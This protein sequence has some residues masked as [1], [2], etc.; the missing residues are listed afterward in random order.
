MS[1]LV[2]RAILLRLELGLSAMY[3]TAAVK[4]GCKCLQPCVVLSVIP[5]AMQPVQFGELP[6]TCHIYGL[7]SLKLFTQLCTKSLPH[8]K[9]GL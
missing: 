9:V 3:I 6:A 1:L 5:S 7:F 8:L 4:P 2:N